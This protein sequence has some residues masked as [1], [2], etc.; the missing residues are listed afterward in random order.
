MFSTEIVHGGAFLATLSERSKLHKKN[1]SAFDHDKAD[2][3]SLVIIGEIF[4]EK[5]YR[6]IVTCTTGKSVATPYSG[7]DRRIFFACDID[8]SAGTESTQIASVIRF[9]IGSQTNQ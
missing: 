9:G 7:S 3:P 2:R 4:L 5:Q 6:Y 1:N 8:N